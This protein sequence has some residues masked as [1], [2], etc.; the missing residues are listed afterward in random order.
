MKD[1]M[2]TTVEACHFNSFRGHMM[3]QPILGIRE[4][5]RR[6]T[7]EMVKEYHATNYIGPNIVVA[8]AG[9]IDHDQLAELAEK[10]FGF[11]PTKAPTGIENRNI[12]KPDFTPSILSMNDVEL[13][14]INLGICY[15]GPGW[16]N[17]DYYPF[18]VLQ[19][20][21]GEYNK[22]TYS[23]VHLDSPQKQFNTLNQYLRQFEELDLQKTV[24]TPYS[25]TG[26]FGSYFHGSPKLVP[27]LMALLPMVLCEYSEYLNEFEVY[28]AKN[29]LYNELLQHE[30]GND[31]VQSIGNQIVYLDRRV[32]RSEIARRVSNIDSKVLN[33]VAFK[34][35]FDQDMS[36]VL[37]GPQEGTL[38]GSTH[39]RHTKRSPLGWNESA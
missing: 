6:I 3:G 12:N 8:G 33:K 31:I 13:P 26:L 25:D 17:P 30:T 16:F 4:N 20:I 7:Q 21:M 37:W 9:A 10:H 35:F 28:R 24:Y 1:Q 38:G 22:D 23:G 15:E 18:L 19:R 29:R 5:I 39:N 34:W 36:V 32:P 27:Q 2:E 14:N 11:L